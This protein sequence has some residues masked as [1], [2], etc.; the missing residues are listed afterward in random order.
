[1][2]DYHPSGRYSFDELDAL[3]DDPNPKVVLMRSG[4]LIEAAEVMAGHAIEVHGAR[5]PASP[6]LKTSTILCSPAHY[7][8]FGCGPGQATYVEDADLFPWEYLSCHWQDV[9]PLQVEALLR[10]VPASASQEA[11]FLDKSLEA[12]WASLPPLARLPR[13][14]EIA[15]AAVGDVAVA[16][17]SLAEVLTRRNS[18]SDAAQR[19][20]ELSRVWTSFDSRISPALHAVTQSAQS[21]QE[22]GSAVLAYATRRGAGALAACCGDPVKAALA[23]LAQAN[24]TARSVARGAL[25]RRPDLLAS[26]WPVLSHLRLASATNDNPGP[27]VIACCG[28]DIPSFE[29]VDN[30]VIA[31]L[32]TIAD[33][34]ARW[35]EQMD[36]L[37]FARPVERLISRFNDALVARDVSGTVRWVSG[38]MDL[39]LGLVL[40]GR[41]LPT[42][43]NW[44]RCV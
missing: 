9:E 8:A 32:P 21:V 38:A 12:L 34:K 39:D 44:E 15:T 11:V 20:R 23:C 17:R 5:R 33:A 30:L 25:A 16:L 4:R 35:L 42:K 22:A 27:T 36:P 14:A 6:L 24:W 18:S 40:A 1:M 31:G 26:T 3:A 41:T 13:P 43:P 29:G 10:G 7:F 2:V 37:V 19:A 28:L